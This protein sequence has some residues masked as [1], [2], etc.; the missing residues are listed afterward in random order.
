MVTTSF[1]QRF[2]QLISTCFALLS[3]RLCQCEQHDAVHAC[4][5]LAWLVDAFRSERVLSVVL[6][7][8]H[9][10]SNW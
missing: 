6:L 3:G 9:I 2:L 1:M 7:T 4:S 10:I 8:D 5:T